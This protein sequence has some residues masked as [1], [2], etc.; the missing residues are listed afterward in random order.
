MGTGPGGDGGTGG[1]GTTAPH[2]LPG[3]EK[4]KGQGRGGEEHLTLMS[5]FKRNKKMCKWNMKR[6]EKVTRGQRVKNV[7]KQNYQK[8]ILT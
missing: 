3:G 2:S 4:R 1:S 8:T 6:P 7:I 5:S